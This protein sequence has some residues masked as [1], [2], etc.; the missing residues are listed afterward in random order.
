MYV[1]VDQ[2]DEEP[3]QNDNPNESGLFSVAGY[4]KRNSGANNTEKRFTLFT[5]IDFFE[6]LQHV[7][8]SDLNLLCVLF[9]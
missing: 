5:I 6:I 9:Y 8:K 7:I 1:K 4:K 2:T 3:K